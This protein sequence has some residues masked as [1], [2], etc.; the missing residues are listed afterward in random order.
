MALL[1]I[2]KKKKAEKKIKKKSVRIEEPAVRPHPKAGPSRAEKPKKI[3]GESYKILEKAHVTEKATALTEKNQYIF[4]V[5]PRSNK[6][7]IKKA[8]EDVYGIDVVAVRIINIP[9]K[10]RRL[11]RIEGWRQGYKKAI[12][13]IKEGQKIEVLPR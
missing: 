12:V 9:K 4:N 6:N 5:F 2:F 7:Q 10:K 11:G 3:L 8:V 1:D 13:K